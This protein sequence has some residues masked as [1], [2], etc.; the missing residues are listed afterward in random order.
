[1]RVAFI[2][3]VI[4]SVA[5]LQAQSKDDRALVDAAHL[6]TP[7]LPHPASRI[8][9]RASCL[10]P[11]AFYLLP[12][13]FCLP[14]S[15]PVRPDPA[16]PLPSDPDARP[17]SFAQRL[18]LLMIL[19]VLPVTAVTLPSLL[20]THCFGQRPRP[21][22]PATP[23]P[24]A[25][26]SGLRRELD[27]RADGLLPTPAPLA[28]EPV[29]V[30][31]LDPSHVGPRAEKVKAQAQRFGGTAVEGLATDGGNICSSICPRARPMDSA[32]RS[33]R[34][35]RWNR[36]RYPPRRLPG[37][38]PRAIRWKC[39]SAPPPTMNSRM[40]RPVV[41]TFAVPDESRGFAPATERGPVIVVHT[42]VGN[43][44]DGRRRLARRAGRG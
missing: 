41:V 18:G 12:S 4:L 23:T 13:A 38:P 30:P 25:D 9:P 33:P 35:R 34:T 29:R 39:S 17:R 27:R 31:V 14:M 40:P 1:M 2:N 10:L 16:P 42:G 6:P 24:P 5:S 21:K 8:P 26:V 28:A 20:L 7:R 32:G 19:L 3:F 43:P 11:A 37:R 22:I 15:L 44:P 36:W